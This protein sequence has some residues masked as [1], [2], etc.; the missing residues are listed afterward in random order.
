MNQSL[1][2]TLPRV[3]SSSPTWGKLVRL[4]NRGSWRFLF[5][6]D[7]IQERVTYSYR[8]SG[9]MGFIQNQILES[10]S[11]ELTIPNLNVSTKHEKRSLQHYINSLES[12]GEPIPGLFSPPVLALT[13][14][15]R[16]L[17]SPCI[18]TDL[19]VTQRDWYSNG[20][21]ATA[22]IRLTLRQVPRD[23]VVNI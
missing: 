10:G 8:T 17:I 20:E 19:Q 11:K 21:L 4:D 9:G 18:V 12:L 23:Q 6:P 3:V 2:Y 15:S 7:Q 22:T 1:L 5:M 14:G 16:T 13:W